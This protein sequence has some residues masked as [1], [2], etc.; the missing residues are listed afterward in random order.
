MVALNGSLK[1]TNNTRIELK[2]I[3]QP[4]TE[5]GVSEQLPMVPLTKIQARGELSLDIPVKVSATL[6]YWSK[7]HADRLGTRELTA[8]LLVG[9]GISTTFVKRTVFSF[10]INNMF[11]SGYEWWSGYPAPGREFKLRVQANIQ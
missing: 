3:F 8:P 11:N 10:E 5:Q 4:T 6:D 7:Q 1:P 9:S 2:T